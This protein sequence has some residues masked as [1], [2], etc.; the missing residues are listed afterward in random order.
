MKYKVSFINDNKLK[1]FINLKKHK[2]RG[3]FMICEICKKN[4]ANVYITKVINGMKQ[5]L[6]ICD[7]CAREKEGFGIEENIS[8]STPFSFQNILSGLMDYVNKP[9]EV[10]RVSELVCKNCGTTYNDFKKTGL[11]GCSECY[12]NFSNTLNPVIKRVQGNVE[13]VGKIP[14][15]LG[16]DIMERKRLTKLKEE[17]QKAIASEEYEKAARIRDEIREIQSME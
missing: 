4:E 11:L 1:R 3:G 8:F 9:S 10:T 15:K 13:H 12:Q 7:K 17:L 16:K 6:R 2:I 5:E 14:K